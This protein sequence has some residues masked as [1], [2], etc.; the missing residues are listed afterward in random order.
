MGKLPGDSGADSDQNRNL[1]REDKK[2]RGY[3]WAGGGEI[4]LRCK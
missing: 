4:I 3:E 2:E 1:I